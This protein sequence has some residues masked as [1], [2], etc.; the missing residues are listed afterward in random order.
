MKKILIIL[1]CFVVIAAGWIF[2]MVWE[3]GQFK[4][5]NPH[6]AGT[7]SQIKG[8]IG[9]EDLTIHPKTGI[10]YI[11]AHDRRA[12]IVGLKAKAGIYGYDL[13][14]PSPSLILLTTG[15]TPDFAPHG[16]SL[17]VGDDGQDVL[18]VV[19]H[20]GGKHSI[21]VFN[22]IGGQ[23][24][25]SRT[26]YDPMLIS[27]ND[28]LAVSPTQFYVTNDHG[29]ESGLMRTVEDYGR[30]AASNVVYYD[31]SV[32]SEAASG[33][34]YANGINISSDKKTVY[35]AAVT[36][37]S[38][39]VMDRDL[40]SGKLTVQK[41]IALGTGPDNI[42]IDAEGDLWVGSHPQLLTFISHAGDPQ[43]LSPSQ[44]LRLSPRN[45]YAIEEVYLSRGEDLSASSVAAVK[46]K[47]LLIG[48]VFDPRIL[49]CRMD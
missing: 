34:S 42:E 5:I 47:R 21:E 39:Y 48:P 4:T 9:A 17:Y 15:P 41:S 6:F 36:G 12:A 2:N 22:L 31:G 11:S 27:P 14:Q 8:I 25:H 23:L 33:F 40:V 46:G 18:V 24:T 19:N 1:I 13:N 38:I 32:F 3:A 20:A 28:I 16:L 29:Y 35:L 30:L 45:G 49:D 44:V 37:R 10:A 26:I 7:C 43:K